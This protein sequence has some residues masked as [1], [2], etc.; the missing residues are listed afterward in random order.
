MPHLMSDTL[1]HPDAVPGIP[2]AAAPA[3]RWAAFARPGGLRE[4]LD[5]LAADRGLSVY[6]DSDTD[7]EDTDDDE[8]EGGGARAPEQKKKGRK[9]KRVSAAAT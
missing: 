9:R 6:M 3:E 4:A 5:R 1:D 2:W 8:E 7:N